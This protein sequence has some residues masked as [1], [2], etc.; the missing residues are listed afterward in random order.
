MKVEIKITGKKEDVKE[1]GER[2]YM[3]LSDWNFDAR[4]K[5]QH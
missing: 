3:T 1:L 2:F 4:R 5:G